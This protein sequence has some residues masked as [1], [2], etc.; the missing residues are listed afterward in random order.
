MTFRTV[1][2]VGKM[3]HDKFTKKLGLVTNN[4]TETEIVSTGERLPK[5]TW[6]RYFRIEQ[7]EPVKEDILLQDNI[8]AIRL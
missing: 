5:T 3:S 7:G 4:S 8:L 6:F 1:L 2:N